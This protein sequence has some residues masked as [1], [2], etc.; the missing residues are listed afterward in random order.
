[1]RYSFDLASNIPIRGRIERCTS[2]RQESASRQKSCPNEL[3]PNEVSQAAAEDEIRSKLTGSRP[4][5]TTLS[6]T[7]CPLYLPPKMSPGF[8]TPMGSNSVLTSLINRDLGMMFA[9][10]NLNINLLAFQFASRE[11]GSVSV[12]LRSS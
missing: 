8:P 12:W 3:L 2:D 10:K 11:N 7:D 6:A 4:L 1:M 5:P 9:D